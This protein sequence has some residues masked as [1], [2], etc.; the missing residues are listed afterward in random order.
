[1][2]RGW[3]G[4]GGGEVNCMFV[5]RTSADS[6]RWYTHLPTAVFSS[7]SFTGCV[8]GRR[9]AHVSVKGRELDWHRY[10]RRC[11]GLHASCVT[12]ERSLD[13]KAEKTVC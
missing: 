3:G 2:G 13:G 1:M 6:C 10:A 11:L 9:T 5:S 7:F 4:E 8:I 12:C